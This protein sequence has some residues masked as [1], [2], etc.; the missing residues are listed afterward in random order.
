MY[1]RFKVQD[2]DF[3]SKFAI[4]KSK[5]YNCLMKLKTTRRSVV[6]EANYGTY[7]YRCAD[8]EY[9]GDGEGRFLC[10]FGFKND[11]SKVEEVKAA[12]KHYG[13]TDGK[14]EYWPGQRPISDEK[15]EEQLARADMGLVP[16][17]L[18]YGAIMDE[19]KAKRYEQRR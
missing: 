13:F 4:R 2:N 18:D 16:D 6:E 15:Y 19:M 5:W 1:G 14:V 3:V 8:G 10:A 17:P 7:V 11:R 12:A 9:L